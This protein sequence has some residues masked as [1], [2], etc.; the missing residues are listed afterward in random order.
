VITGAGLVLGVIVSGYGF[1][2]G[3]RVF[4]GV[5]VQG[6]EAMH[7]PAG[8]GRGWDTTEVRML[9]QM[10]DLL[11]IWYGNGSVRYESIRL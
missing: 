3:A 4:M 1:W 10:P 2:S 6:N 5:F 8:Y 9:R 11:L 7:R